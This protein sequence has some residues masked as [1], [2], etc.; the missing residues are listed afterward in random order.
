VSELIQSLHLFDPSN[1]DAAA[2]DATPAFQSTRQKELMGQ[3]AS[4]EAK[5]KQ[6]TRLREELRKKEEEEKERKEAQAQAER[7]RKHRQKELMAKIASLDA[8]AKQLKEKIA[9]AE[10]RDK[11]AE[12]AKKRLM[13]HINPELYHRTTQAILERWETEHDQKMGLMQTRALAAKE[14]ALQMIL[15]RQTA[16]AAENKK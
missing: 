5:A 12:T 4:L 15:E 13:H 14:K 1:V 7:E 3:N 9:L 2:A 11:Q 16:S 10:A 8:K 6:L